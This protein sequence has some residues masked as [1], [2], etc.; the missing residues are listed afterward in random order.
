ME[1]IESVKIA[2]EDEY[3]SDMEFIYIYVTTATVSS[4]TKKQIQISTDKIICID[5]TN[6]EAYIP[7]NL[8]PYLGTPSKKEIKM[9]EFMELNRIRRPGKNIPLSK[10]DMKEILKFLGFVDQKEYSNLNFS[11]LFSLTKTKIN[12]HIKDNSNKP[13]NSLETNQF[14]DYDDDNYDDKNE[15]LYADEE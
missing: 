2:F 10:G 9:L 12:E 3:T 5:K 7:T 6:I 11:L 1:W 13:T 8:L 15:G 14:L 4:E